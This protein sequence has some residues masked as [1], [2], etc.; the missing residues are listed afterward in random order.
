MTT[1]HWTA[2]NDDPHI[3]SLLLN[4]I[5]ID[6]AIKSGSGFDDIADMLWNHE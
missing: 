5:S 1:L 6:T 2:N 3:V 4:C